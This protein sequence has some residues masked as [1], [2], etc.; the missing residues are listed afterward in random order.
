MNVF[1]CHGK[2]KAIELKGD[3]FLI[4]LQNAPDKLD[5]EKP[6]QS[7]RK[8]TV[9]LRKDRFPSDFEVEVGMLLEVF[10]H[11]GGICK[12]NMKDGS[13]YAYAEVMA[14]SI[15]PASLID[16]PGN[17][18]EKYLNR[19]MCSG[20]LRYLLEPETDH[21]K[22]LVGYVQVSAMRPRLDSEKPAFRKT[23]TIPVKFFGQ[24]KEAILKANADDNAL[25]KAFFMTG[26]VNGILTL[27]PNKDGS[28]LR[29]ELHPQ[30]IISHVEVSPSVPEAMLSPIAF[31]E[32]GATKMTGHD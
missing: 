25:S 1:L 28:Q 12:H 14:S 32:G 21:K 20:I 30:V 29:N 18:R 2:V 24:A 17:G 13:D 31:L 5:P 4:L 6:I 15:S 27:A 10:G 19:F 8:F 3:S 9:R 7:T 23:D 22:P 11:V 26:H 16:P